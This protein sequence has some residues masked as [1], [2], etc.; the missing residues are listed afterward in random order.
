MR[1]IAVGALV[2]LVVAVLGV[3]QVLRA[4]ARRRR[5]RA[6]F[7]ALWEPEAYQV[8]DDHH[9]ETRIDLVLLARWGHRSWVVERDTSMPP[10]LLPLTSPDYSR[11]LAEHIGYAQADCTARNARRALRRKEN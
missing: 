8:N 7:E 10:L 1:L 2:L 5:Q 9:D 4:V 6:E 11:L 3:V